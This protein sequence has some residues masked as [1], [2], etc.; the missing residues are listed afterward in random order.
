MGGP[1]GHDYS[2]HPFFLSG[3]SSDENVALPSRWLRERVFLGEKLVDE[4]VKTVLRMFA[5]R[6]EVVMNRPFAT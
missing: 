1:K 6:P 3:I 5:H 4:K 2:L